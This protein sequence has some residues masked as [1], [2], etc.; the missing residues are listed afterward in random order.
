MYLPIDIYFR[1]MRFMSLVKLTMLEALKGDFIDFGREL[2]NTEIFQQNIS[3][4]GT[5]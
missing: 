3:F 2:I 1:C 4:V 5:Q